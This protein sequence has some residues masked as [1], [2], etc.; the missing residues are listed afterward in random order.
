MQTR[1]YCR[2]IVVRAVDS[3]TRMRLFARLQVT[4]M[5]SMRSFLDPPAPKGHTVK[6]SG[7]VAYKLQTRNHESRL[8]L[9]GTELH[10]QVK[11]AFIMKR[12]LLCTL[13]VLRSMMLL[14]TLKSY[15]LFNMRTLCYRAYFY[16]CTYTF[17]YH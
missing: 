1:S 7:R 16:S 15:L 3:E 10:G 2:G 4:E 11:N 13:C 12:A 5:T 6:G 8:V 17:T 14:C 9:E